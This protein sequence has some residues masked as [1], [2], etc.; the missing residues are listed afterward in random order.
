MGIKMIGLGAFLL[1]L[2]NGLSSWLVAK[3]AGYSVA[4]K[5]IQLLII[6]LVPMLGAVVCVLVIRA[7]EASVPDFEEQAKNGINEHDSGTAS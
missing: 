3:H 1:L 6:W 7:D 4:Q 2:L 5:C